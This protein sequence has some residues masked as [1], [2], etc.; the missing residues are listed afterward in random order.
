MW[1]RL[2]PSWV[3]SG[4]CCLSLRFFSLETEDLIL[5]CQANDIFSWGLYSGAED[6]VQSWPSFFLRIP[7]PV[8]FPF[9]D[10][11]STFCHNTHEKA[12]FKIK[13]KFVSEPGLRM[14]RPPP[15]FRLTPPDSE[16]VVEQSLPLVSGGRSPVLLRNHSFSE[17][18]CLDSWAHTAFWGNQNQDILGIFRRN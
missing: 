15:L 13:A 3:F 11:T 9:L 12:D 2:F 14:L 18:K 6:M 8:T 5:C 1:R 4:P 10:A 16:S 17:W 7:Y